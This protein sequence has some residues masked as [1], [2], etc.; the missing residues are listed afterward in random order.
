MQN[1]QRTVLWIIF[2]LSILFIWDAWQKHEGRPSMFAPP[3]PKAAVDKNAANGKNG[4]AP[5]AD[6]V[7]TSGAAIPA[8]TAGAATPA[9]TAAVPGAEVGKVASS[10]VTV[11][12]DVLKLEI[13]VNG[14]EIRRAE[15]L[16]Q[17]AIEGAGNLVLMSTENGKY[18]VAQSGLIG[19]A[20]GAERFPNHRSEMTLADGKKSGTIEL[21]NGADSVQVVLVGQSGGVKL[22]KTYTLQ[23]GKYDIAV[24]HQVAN[25]GDKPVTPT[26]YMQ[27]TRDGNK[28]VGESQ[29]YSTYTG[30]VVYTDAKK[31]E[32]VDFTDIEKKKNEHAKTANDGW[33]GIIQHY[34]VSAWVPADKAAREYETTSLD[35]NLYTVR[36]KQALGA[37]APGASVANQAKLFIGP[38]DQ[39][40][41]ESVAA[42][43]D[44]AV[45]YGWLTPIAKPLYWLLEFLHGKVGNW[46]WAIV[47]LTL[48]VKMAFFPLQAASYKSMARMKAVQPKM[49][50]IREKY[51]N[52][53]MAM[54][55]K[56]MEL[57]K[58]EKINPLGGCLPVV[59]QIPVFIAL[60]WAL[61]ASVEMR[62]APWIGWIKDLSAPDPFYI[63]PVIMAVSM[64]VQTKLNPTPPDP[65]Q[66]KM[67]MWMPIIFSVMFFFFPAGLVLYW[68]VNNCFSI[69]QQW[70]I[71]R[72]IAGPEAASLLPVA[73]NDASVSNKK[74]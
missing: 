23:R 1:I 6:G 8:G 28:P 54:N 56:V 49:T 16:K 65:M 9:S 22:T 41:M 70:F 35:K 21:A 26:L 15:L 12:T 40:A 38:Q 13:D 62:N 58:A 44:L 52:D 24:S 66:A 3:P 17:R 72:K 46:G 51:G 29:F 20:E 7:P 71:T 63:L 50:A 64:F 57:Y 45:D 4:A 2:S 47:L 33:V 34:F 36:A 73:A 48:I 74:K 30:P 10:V 14:G 11:M 19:A 69:V 59:I 25:I 68:V 27:L 60:Y 32:K 53:R 55:Q 61:L 67:M 42:G 37:V 18:Y 39:K 5:K 31:F 43:L